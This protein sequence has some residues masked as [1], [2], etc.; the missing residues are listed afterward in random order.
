MPRLLDLANELLDDIWEYI[1]GNDIDSFRLSCKRLRNL[2]DPGRLME[3]REAK[4]RFTRIESRWLNRLT[5]CEFPQLLQSFLL[6]PDMADYV[7]EMLVD[8]WERWFDDSPENERRN[9]WQ[10]RNEWPMWDLRGRYHSYSESMMREFEETIKSTGFISS[11]ERKFWISKTKVGNQNPI[12]ALLF[13]RLRY[14]TRLVIRMRHCEDHF[15][16]KT[17]E[18]IAK[19]WGSP[20]LSRL[21]EVEIVGTAQPT[22]NIKLAIACAALPSIISL[23][24]EG[25]IEKPMNPARPSSEP[26]QR[27]S[28]V[29]N[30]QI[31][32]CRLSQRMLSNFIGSPKV[33]R[34]FSYICTTPSTHSSI[35]W[36]RAALLQYASTSLKNLAL[37]CPIANQVWT[38]EC[39]FRSYSNL[40]VLH[41]DYRLL[42]G[43]LYR[44]TDKITTLL[45]SS[46]QVL[47]LHGCDDFDDDKWVP[48]L[49]KWVA[50]VKSRLVPRLKKLDF[51]MTSFLY[52]HANFQM[53]DL[54][55]IGL[56]AGIRVTFVPDGGGLSLDWEYED[57]EEGDQR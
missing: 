14:L 55:A 16:L 8:G 27:S 48:E 57:W 39:S 40:R 9:P 31:K 34:S 19:D 10:S 18:R 38:T 46:I 41:V 33:L 35:A 28:T 15:M 42:M 43:Q 37:H 17:L 22:H 3:H 47:G 53:L 5:L 56:E 36:A 2:A 24:V 25:L 7:R 26:A 44:A 30:L 29:R 11:E 52:L 13:P 4:A 23:S 32:D 21:R 20:S 50:R 1:S 51:K 49:V 54:C 45:P 12:I 6:E